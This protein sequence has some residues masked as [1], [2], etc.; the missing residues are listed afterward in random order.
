MK[1]LL[2]TEFKKCKIYQIDAFS[3]KKLTAQRLEYKNAF[4]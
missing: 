1:T 3:I 4:F 2:F